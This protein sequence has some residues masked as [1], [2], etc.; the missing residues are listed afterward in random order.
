VPDRFREY[1]PSVND[2][3]PILIVGGAPR[4]AV[5]A[6]R[7]LTVAA[8]GTTAVTLAG[9]LRSQGRDVH[10]LLSQDAAPGANAERYTDRDGLE[11]G[12]GAW[13][14]RHAAGCV[15]MSAAVNDY[16]VVG[17]ERWEGGDSRLLR[18]GEKLPSGADEVVIRLREASKVIDRLR[19][20][21][22]LIGPIIGFKYED[23]ATVLASA[24]ALRQRVDATCVVANSLC[25]AVQAI[26]DASG[27]EIYPTRDE[28][29]A[30][31]AKRI[32]AA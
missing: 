8:T 9:M 3:R 20:E 17:V 24:E 10:L 30:A 6:V 26:V 28:L 16:R 19:S 31:L 22:G 11:N 25:G 27:N 29:L 14:A 13:I 18:P 2:S 7:H 15:V 4:V 5:D 12:I 21:F 1:T 23:R 32:A